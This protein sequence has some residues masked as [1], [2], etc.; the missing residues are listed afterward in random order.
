M[1]LCKLGYKVSYKILPDS[2]F[3]IFNLNKGKKSRR[4]LTRG[5]ATPNIQR[6][7]HTK[8][9]QS[10]Q[11]K[12]ITNYTRLLNSTKSKESISA[13]TKDLKEKILSEIIKRKIQPWM[14]YHTTL[15]RNGITVNTM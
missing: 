14:L 2:L 11:C 3:T 12:S 15:K 4:Y 7:G 13:F 10:F 1:E 6:H 9:N 8:F 5:K